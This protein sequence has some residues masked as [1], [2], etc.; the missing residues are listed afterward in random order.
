MQ[1]LHVDALRTPNLSLVICWSAHYLICIMAATLVRKN[2]LRSFSPF[3]LPIS[4]TLHWCNREAK[5]NNVTALKV[6][7]FRQFQKMAGYSTST[8]RSSSLDLSGIFPPIVT[9]FED[10]EEVNYD[11]LKE[12]FSKWNEIP[13]RGK[14]AFILSFMVFKVYA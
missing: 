4:R 2:N 7:Q 5:C 10:N 8:T 9:P 3:I 1:K 6:S 12:N 11:K 14:R 13:F